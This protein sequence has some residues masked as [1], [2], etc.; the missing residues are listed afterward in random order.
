MV[1]RQPETCIHCGSTR[2]AEILY[3]L[4]AFSDELQERLNQGSV[5]LGGCMVS[6][7]NPKWACADC[8][9]RY[10]VVQNNDQAP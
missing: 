8:G 1:L 9:A 2:I 6:E 7:D 10:P 5:V 4:P 3:G